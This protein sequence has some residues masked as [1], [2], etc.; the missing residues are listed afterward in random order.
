M[1]IIPDPGSGPAPAPAPGP[2]LTVHDQ[3]AARLLGDVQ[4][5]MQT[6]RGYG[7]FLNPKHVRFIN[8]T[9]SLPTEFL[10]AVAVALDASEKLRNSAELTGDQIRDVISFCNAYGPAA[11]EMRLKSEGVLQAVKAQRY[12]VGQAALRIYRVARSN[13]LPSDR[14]LLFPHVENMKRTLGRGPKKKVK[15]K[16]DPNAAK[17]APKEGAANA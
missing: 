10:L 5:L 17:T 2:S 14:E 15:A 4:S 16:E 1:S 12:A 7:S 8:P 3:G 9:A 6:V 11:D 13:T